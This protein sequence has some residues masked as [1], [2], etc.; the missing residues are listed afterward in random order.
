M[1]QSDAQVHWTQYCRRLHDVGLRIISEADFMTVDAHVK[2]P[3][4][5][6][7]ALLCRTLTNFNAVVMLVEAA[8]IVEARTLTRS[9]F[10]NLLWLAELAHRKEEFVAEMVK[11][12]IASQRGRGRM[13]LSWAERLE[14]GAEF[15]AGLRRR[16][17]EMALRHPKAKAI[18]FSDLGKDN[19]VNDSYMWFKVLSADAAHPSL[20]SL[21]RYFKNQSDSVLQLSVVPAPRQS[22]SDQTLQ[23]AAQAL[24]GVCVATCEICRVPK[25]HAA[26]GPMFDEFIALAEAT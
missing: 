25:A 12:E 11:D 9:C 6:A 3:K 17:D 24:L 26:L 18:R 20:N 21:S 2:D 13:A 4:V 1:D 16:L 23:F 10:E 8:L 14:E 15:E 5:L 22:E 7:L 19:N